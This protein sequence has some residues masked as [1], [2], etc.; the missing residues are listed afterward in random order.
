M[1]NSD[2]RAAYI[3]LAMSVFCI[4]AALIRG[5]ADKALEFAQ[6]ALREVDSISP[7]LGQEISCNDVTRR[8]LNLVATPVAAQRREGE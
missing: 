5:W 1:D 2:L 8:M 4:E 7:K 3:N 6:S